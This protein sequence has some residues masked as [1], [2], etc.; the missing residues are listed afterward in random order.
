MKKMSRSPAHSLLSSSFKPSF[1][2]FFI[3]IYIFW[4]I[5]PIHH[6]RTYTI[7]K[8]LSPPLPLGG[9]KFFFNISV[10]GRRVAGGTLGCACVCAVCCV[11]VCVGWWSFF[12]SSVSLHSISI[13]CHHQFITTLF[14]FPC[15]SSTGEKVSY[16]SIH[17]STFHPFFSIQ[18]LFFSFSLYVLNLWTDWTLGN[19]PSSFSYYC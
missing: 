2:F 17:P 5:Q 14:F 10:S 6:T 19:S 15:R 8:K 16:L 12:T 1:L 18:L 3:L 13:H 9:L 7:P 11:C 4:A